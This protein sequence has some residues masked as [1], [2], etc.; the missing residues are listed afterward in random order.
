M[1]HSINNY[2]RLIVAARAEQILENCKIHVDVAKLNLFNK[3]NT[4]PE[5][6][7]YILSARETGFVNTS[8][9]SRGKITARM[10]NKSGALNLITLSDSDILKCINSRYENGFIV[11]F[12][13]SAYEFGIICNILHYTDFDDIDVPTRIANDLDIDRDVAKKLIYGVMY[14]MANST[15]NSMIDEGQQDLF[16]QTF[17]DLFAAKE[18]Y[19]ANQEDLF[20]STQYV[21]NSFGRKIY[22]K[23]KRNIFNNIIQS[24]GS[25]ILMDTICRIG[26]LNKF[27]LLFHRFD[28]LFFDIDRGSLKQQVPEIIELMLKNERSFKLHTSISIGESLHNL[29]KLK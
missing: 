7:K 5:K 27:N 20:S 25:E 29:K 21:I 23:Q 26:S 15:V 19:L 16:Y 13:Y 4:T 11:E 22:P 1:D 2:K 18:E 24:N 9:S 3:A 10:F 8:Y 17:S 6:Q 12:D 28:S 14:G